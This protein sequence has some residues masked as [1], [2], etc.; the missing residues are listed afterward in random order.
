RS[1]ADTRLKGLRQTLSDRLILGPV[2]RTQELRGGFRAASK[3]IDFVSM[4]HLE[5]MLIVGVGFDEI[6]IQRVAGGIE[7][8]AE[9]LGRLR[10]FSRLSPL[11][12]D[13]CAEGW[14]GWN[15]IGLM[16]HVDREIGHDAA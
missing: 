16:K 3:Q 9:E 15:A 6:G 10:D 11:N 12:A 7:D 2:K 14:G 4:T 1:I 8:D 13:F 5:Q